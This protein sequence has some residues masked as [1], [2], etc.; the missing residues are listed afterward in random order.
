MSFFFC[1]LIVTFF[2]FGL[3]VTSFFSVVIMRASSSSLVAIAMALARRGCNWL[4][5]RGSGAIGLSQNGYGAE[6]PEAEYLEADEAVA[7]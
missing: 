1:G 2:F 6:R 3:I 4:C 5:W 7:K